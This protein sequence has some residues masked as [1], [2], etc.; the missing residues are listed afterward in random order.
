M[1]QQIKDIIVNGE[2]IGRGYDVPSSDYYIR[3]YQSL[4][5]PVIGKREPCTVHELVFGSEHRGFMP[6]GYVA[7]KQDGTVYDSHF[8]HVNHASIME[9]LMNR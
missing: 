5:N 9:R 6:C 8:E 1:K 2:A 7:F 3:V 4:T